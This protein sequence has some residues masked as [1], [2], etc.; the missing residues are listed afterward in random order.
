MWKAIFIA[1]RVLSLGAEQL[2]HDLL[3]NGVQKL[4]PAALTQNPK[5]YEKLFSWIFL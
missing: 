5:K 2:I 4:A 1:K 3:I